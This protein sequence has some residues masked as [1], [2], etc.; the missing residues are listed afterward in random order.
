MQGKH[1]SRGRVK[2]RAGLRVGKGD[3]NYC[4]LCPLR[5]GMAGLSSH[6]YYKNI[7]PLVTGFKS[8]AQISA[9]VVKTTALTQPN[10]LFSGLS[11]NLG[12]PNSFGC[13]QWNDFN[14][15]SQ[16]PYK[17]ENKKSE[18]VNQPRWCSLWGRGFFRL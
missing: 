9:Q 13:P 17:G 8:S 1:A 12:I 5:A 18:A 10:S 2:A 11:L 14:L 15:F 4:R 16:R 7:L 3:N 6:V